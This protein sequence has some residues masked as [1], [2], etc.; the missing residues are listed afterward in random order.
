MTESSE[1]T[2]LPRRFGP[3]EGNARAGNHP[4]GLDAHGEGGIR[5]TAVNMLDIATAIRDQRPGLAG[6][7][8]LVFTMNKYQWDDDE[9]IT[10][11]VSKRAKKEMAEALVGIDQNELIGQLFSYVMRQANPSVAESHAVVYNATYAGHKA[12]NMNGFFALVE[13]IPRMRVLHIEDRNTNILDTVPLLDDYERMRDDDSQTLLIS[14]R[15]HDMELMPEGE[16]QIL[17][18]AFIEMMRG[19]IDNRGTG[20]NNQMAITWWDSLMDKASSL[21]PRRPLS[22]AAARAL[23]RR[24]DTAAG[25]SG[26]GA[27]RHRDQRGF[28]GRASPG[29]QPD[30]A[31]PC[32]AG[33]GISFSRG[34]QSEP[35]DWPERSLSLKPARGPSDIPQN[36]KIGITQSKAFK[37]PRSF[38][39]YKRVGGDLAMGQRACP[40]AHELDKSADRILRSDIRF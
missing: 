4:D 13:D 5:D 30:R 11:P 16:Q 29:V 33:P 28:L 17:E 1:P 22:R 10:G 35:A 31:P 25:D 18:E 14:E 7:I 38:Q 40:D 36:P 37:A 12:A 19:Y 15:A 32:R 26:A 27:E 8:K 2:E 24:A 20:W 23:G 3:A 34:R 39:P 9:L 21:T 6:Q